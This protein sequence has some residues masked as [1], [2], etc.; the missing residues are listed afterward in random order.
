MRSFTAATVILTYADAWGAP[1]ICLESSASMSFLYGEDKFQY[2][3]WAVDAVLYNRLKDVTQGH[4][5]HRTYFPVF[6]HSDQA[7]LSCRVQ[8][9]PNHDVWLPLSI[10]VWV[11]I[12]SDRASY[13]RF[14][15]LL[16]DVL[17]ALAALTPS[18]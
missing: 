15:F 8:M 10:P 17:Q 4:G 5:M 1:P 7:S 2:C 3:S 9:A 14:F 11:F 6:T 12:E 18:L 16:H 13:S